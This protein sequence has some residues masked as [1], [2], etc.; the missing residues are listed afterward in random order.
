[1]IRKIR[2]GKAKKIAEKIGLSFDED[3]SATDMDPNMMKNS[4]Q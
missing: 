2:K 3:I 4:K 1:M